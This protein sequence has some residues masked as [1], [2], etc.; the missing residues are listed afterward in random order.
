MRR[1]YSGNSRGQSVPASCGMTE[2]PLAR[3]IGFYKF[4]H[5]S[6]TQITVI[7]VTGEVNVCS[8]KLPL[9]CIFLMHKE[10]II[11]IS[12]KNHVFI[13]VVAIQKTVSFDAHGAIRLNI[14]LSKLSIIVCRI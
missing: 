12:L 1:R 9:S 7:M 14:E 11:T 3:S 5:H 2:A 13:N 10:L 8:T 4:I 6:N